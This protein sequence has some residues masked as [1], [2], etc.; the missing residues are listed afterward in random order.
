MLGLRKPRVASGRKRGG[1]SRTAG[2]GR[3]RTP[4]G[5]AGSWRGGQA[6]S[7]SWPGSPSPRGHQ[8]LRPL[9]TG[10]G[11]EDFPRTQLTAGVAANFRAY[12]PHL[13]PASCQPPGLREGAFG[14]QLYALGVEREEWGIWRLES[15]R[16][17]LCES[18]CLLKTL[19]PICRQLSSPCIL[20]W[21]RKRERMQAV[22]CLLL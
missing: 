5:L 17:E 12:N 20:T 22:L 1:G 19:F 7:I 9:R 15:P 3:Q 16:S 18:Q 11:A 21:E 13:P 10:R 4:R 2:R 8:T 6:G 14:A